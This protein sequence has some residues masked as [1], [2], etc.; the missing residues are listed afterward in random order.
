MESVVLE[1]THY[2]NINT[3]VC[4]AKQSSKSKIDFLLVWIDNL[5][6]RIIESLPFINS[7]FSGCIFYS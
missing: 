4:E 6:F 1:V 7:H 2:E 5:K 3:Q